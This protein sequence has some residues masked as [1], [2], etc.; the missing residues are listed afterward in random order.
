LLKPGDPTSEEL[1]SVAALRVALRRFLAATDT[2]TAAHGLT[3]RQ[4][5]LL[6]LLHARSDD[7]LTSTAIADRLCL[8]RSATTELVTRAAGAGLIVRSGDEADARMKHIAP[9]R[10]G[11]R[12]FYAAVTDLRAER[13]RLLKLL[14]V[15]AGLAA[16]LTTSV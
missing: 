1:E 9:T 16:T 13:Y 10:E 15:A 8:S 4:Y 7:A 3:P 2:V 6:A 11:T 14:R 5:D 12:R